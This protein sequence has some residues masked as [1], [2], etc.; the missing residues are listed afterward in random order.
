MAL[1]ISGDTVKENLK[2]NFRKLLIS[3]KYVKLCTSE[4]PQFYKLGICVQNIKR[5]YQYSW[6]VK[7]QNTIINVHFQ[8]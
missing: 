5:L 4:T 8:V 7:M 3:I 2:I 1:K 6:V